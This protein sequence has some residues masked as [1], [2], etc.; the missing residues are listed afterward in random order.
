MISERAINRTTTNRPVCSRVIHCPSITD[1]LLKVYHKHQKNYKGCV[2]I[3][4]KI[5]L[6]WEIRDR[7]GE[8]PSPA[9]HFQSGGGIR[10]GNRPN[11]FLVLHSP[12]LR[13]WQKL[14]TPPQQRHSIVKLSESRMTRRTRRTRIFKSLLPKTLM[15]FGEFHGELNGSALSFR[16]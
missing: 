10:S 16:R 6:L 14:Y 13:R 9:F 3:L 5:L 12:P 11:P 4:S 8:V 15:K 2:N 1:M 7:R